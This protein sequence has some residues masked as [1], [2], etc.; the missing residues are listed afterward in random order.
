[1][2]SKWLDI[3]TLLAAYHYQCSQYD[4]YRP[5]AFGHHQK[6]KNITRER[7]REKHATKSETLK[8]L[9]ESLEAQKAEETLHKKPWFS[10]F[11]RKSKPNIPQKEK[12]GTAKKSFSRKRESAKNISSG[13]EVS[14]RN[15]P[16]P[17]KF[18]EQFS[19]SATAS[20]SFA[21]KA[22]GSDRTHKS[23]LRNVDRIDI[24]CPSLFL[25]ETCH[26]VSL[27]SGVALSTLRNDIDGT[28]SPL[29]EYF[30]GQP[31]PAVDPD[32]LPAEIRQD[33]ESGSRILSSLYFLLGLTR[34]DKHRTLYNAARPFQ[35]LGGVS[36]L[37]IQRIQ[38]AH[39]PYAKVSLCTM[40]L[41]EFVAREYQSGST[42]SIP[43]PLISRITHVISDGMTGYVQQI[44]AAVFTENC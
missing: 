31:M 2:H 1:M 37:E 21:T 34:D 6:L 20:R 8:Q 39:G 32:Q 9:H 12:I 38:M 43:G 3:A 24:P 10:I 17:R 30:P 15:I 18:H 23:V 16:A 27:L 33:W 13:D 4:K 26:L 44:M 42:G 41:H 19:I 22:A 14:K 11:S 28:N 36:D 25:Q 7:E 29:A 40:F 35:I 5:P